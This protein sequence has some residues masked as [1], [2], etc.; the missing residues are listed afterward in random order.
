MSIGVFFIAVIIIAGK[1]VTISA[2]AK[3][4]LINQHTAKKAIDRFTSALCWINYGITKKQNLWQRLD[5]ICGKDL[6]IVG[7]VMIF[8]LDKSFW[9]A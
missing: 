1:T 5:E 4:G 9:Q 2:F 7:L 3:E 6:I 8:S